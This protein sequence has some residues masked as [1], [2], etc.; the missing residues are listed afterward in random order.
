[1]KHLFLLLVIG[2]AATVTAGGTAA[3]E[4]PTYNPPSELVLAGG[5]PQSA[6]L[7]QPFETNLRVMLAA[8][9]GCPITT[10]LAGVAVTFSAPA[11][12][13][14]GTFSASGSNA[15][16]V[17]TDASGGATAPMLTANRLAGGYLV[18]ATS[19]VGS[20]VF[21]LV[22]T[23]TGVPATMTPVSP[24]TQRSTVETRYTEP[25]SV[26]VLD[27]DGA[28]V[29]GATVTFQLGSD[30][31][32]VTGGAVATAL[33]RAGGVAISPRFGASGVA[34]RFS[35]T[36]TIEGVDPVSFSLVNVAAKP[37][38]IAAAPAQA[39]TVGTRFHRPLRIRVT[40]GSGRPVEGQS[41]TFALG[42][43]AAGAGAS[44]V[45]GVSQTTATTDAAGFA[46]SPPL[47]A[48]TVAGRYTAT[49]TAGTTTTGLALL[50]VA[51]EPHALA[52]AAATTQSTPGGTRF[53]VRL[54]V[55]VTDRYGNAV[56]G[57]RVRFTA[58]ARGPRGVFVR[59]VSRL[60]SVV[61]RTN[62]AGVAVAPPFV[63]GSQRGG[64]AVRAT[65]GPAAAAFALVNEP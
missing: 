59:G 7:G 30:A 16:L 32:F 29:V 56:A 45:G 53:P 26:K 37:L 49:V 1:M 17:G 36:A 41:V 35:G 9:N 22:N 58:P 55:T 63:A 23:A 47:V 42:A 31:T 4:C 3:A 60:R 24:V 10:P 44:F 39:A 20:V 62:A 61:V 43:A 6:K 38:H 33:T 40:E 18:A 21:S 51:G 5:T 12:G 13:P 65:A 8:A 34:G 28:P 64:Y 25:L 46:S 52:A 15:V 50:N 48:N 14:S 27:A 2:L 19:Q 54:A 57:A 11:S